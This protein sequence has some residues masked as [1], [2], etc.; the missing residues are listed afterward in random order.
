M[1]VS[2]SIF[3]RTK[4]I[5]IGQIYINA[6]HILYNVKPRVKIITYQAYRILFPGINVF[7]FLVRK[8]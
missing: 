4:N 7:L 3:A 1:Y 8:L 2:L 6:K 5:N